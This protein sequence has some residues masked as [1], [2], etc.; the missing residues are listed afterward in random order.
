MATQ[1]EDLLSIVCPGFDLKHA[2]EFQ[3]NFTVPDE[4]AARLAFDIL[5]S[6]GFDAKV[7]P[8]DDNNNA[9]KLYITLPTADMDPALIEQRLLCAIAYGKALNDI[10]MRMD[11]LCRDDAGLL[12]SPSYTLT[13][14]N[15]GGSAKQIVIGV[16]NAAAQPQASQGLSAPT[17][18]RTAA[19]PAQASAPVARKPV[20]KK[21]DDDGF[22]QGPTVAKNFYS[23]SSKKDGKKGDDDLR[24]RAFLFITGNI[25]TGGAGMM[26]ALIM[27]FIA[28]SFFVLAKGFLCPDFAV[29]K[30][31]KNRAW[32]C[33]SPTKQE[34]DPNKPKLPEF[35]EMQNG[36]NIR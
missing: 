27:L 12:Q 26:G 14:A 20:K 22:N 10:K 2:T 35:P 4:K 30:K 13:F 29:E 8:D 16:S 34:E 3:K 15:S 7:Y 23:G 36:G 31:N 25:A 5:V 11:S 21:D 24:R 1:F 28:F 17:A 18:Q 6:Y 19:Q 33:D 32:Y 9:A